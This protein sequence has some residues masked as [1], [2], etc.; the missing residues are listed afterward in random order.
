M[1]S[2]AI[3]RPMSSPVDIASS[4][5]SANGHEP[6]GVE[7]PDAEE[8][9][10]D[11]ERHRMDR[12][13]QR[14]SPSTDTRGSR[15]RGAPPPRSEPRCRRPSQKT[16]SAPSATDHDLR[17]RERERRRPDEP[18]RREQREERIDVGPEPHDLLARR[19]LGHLE[20]MAVGR[21]PD[22]LHHVPEVEA[23]LAEVRVAAAGD[24]EEHAASTPTIAGPD[25][26][27][28]RALAHERPSRRA[29]DGPDARPR[30]D[31]RRAHAGRHGEARASSAR[32]RRDRAR[33]RRSARR[34]SARR[35]RASTP[36]LNG[37]GWPLPGRDDHAERKEPRRA[38]AAAARARRRRAAARSSAATRSASARATPRSR[39]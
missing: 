39:R 4:A 10:R 5:H 23:P 8:V 24:E 21:A 30:A 27:R 29:L 17:E 35:R 36:C 9:E 1:P 11:R 33:S 6:L 32:T 19:G 25:D 28:P 18:E 20:R 13:C 3:G 37:D 16:G 14:S 2:A 15:A 7:E 26:E 12:R 38:R 22:R 34:R 31:G